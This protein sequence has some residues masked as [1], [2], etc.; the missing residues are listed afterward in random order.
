MRLQDEIK[1]A[2][3]DIDSTLF[4]HKEGA[5]TP[6]AVKALKTLDYN[7][8]V[9][10]MNEGHSSFLTLELIKNIMEEKQILF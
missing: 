7:P 2:I 1:I 3:F 5:F 8:S 10:H 9:Y 6:S 4:D